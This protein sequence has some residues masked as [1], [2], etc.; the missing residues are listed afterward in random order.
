MENASTTLETAEK[1]MGLMDRM[2][3]DFVNKLLPT[4]QEGLV[5]TKDYFIDLFGRYVKFLIATD[6][7]MLIAASLTLYTSWRM[8]KKFI[9][10]W[11]ETNEAN[12]GKQYYE[13]DTDSMVV[14]G[15]VIAF[16]MM[17]GVVSTGVIFEQLVDIS[18]AVF[19]PEVR[20][21]EEVSTYIDNHNRASTNQ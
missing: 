5:I 4:V 15:M 12:K 13:K 21:Y 1:A 8:S 3:D 6:I 19:I 10:K 16:S 18:K 17:V 11:K 9:A 2:Y 7:L 20:V 14:Y